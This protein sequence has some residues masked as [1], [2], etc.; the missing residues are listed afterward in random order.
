MLRVLGWSKSVGGRESKREKVVVAMSGG[1]DS[2]M[3]AVLLHEQGY[4]V[5]G[6]MMSLWAEEG[7]PANRC[8]SPQAIEGAHQVCQMLGV[9][10]H[11]LDF[12]GEFKRHVVDYFIAEYGRGRTPNPCLVCNRK[13]KFG[14]LLRE[15]LESGARYL[16]TGHY[17]RVRRIKGQYQLLKGTDASKDQ[18]YVLYMLG[19]DE[20]AHLLLPLGEYTKEE[21]RTMARE[22]G[23][24]VAEREESQE[25]CFTMGDY[26]PFLRKQPGQIFERGPIMDVEGKVI[27]QHKGLPAYTIGQREGLG[28]AAPHPLYVLEI[29]VNRNALVVGP[30]SY[31]ARQELTAKEVSLVS[32]KPPLEPLEIMAKIRYRASEAKATLTFVGG[33]EVRVRFAELQPAITPGQGVVFYQGETVI[34]GGIIEEVK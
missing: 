17:A 10:F 22:R 12:E 27:G 19:Q 31:L 18:S 6:V 29:D 8:C 5:V 15:A 21:V 28:I 32:G 3:A 13:I 2:S 34:G 9:P 1:V 4:E 7:G 16:A 25:V 33:E 23:L 26:R 11:V 14:L 30:R 24:P 20:L